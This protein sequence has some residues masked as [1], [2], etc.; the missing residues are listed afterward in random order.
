M[1][2]VIAI[3]DIGKTNKKVILFDSKLKPVYQFEQ[4]FVE[5]TDESGFSCDDIDSISKWMIETL[6]AFTKAQEF[7]IKAINFSCYGA[8]LVY[9]DAAGKVLTPVYNYLKPM[10]D[11]ISES[12][13]SKY[14]GIKEFSRRTASPALGFL[15]SGLQP[16]WLKNTYPE[17]FRKIACILHFP[18]YWSYLF[19]GKTTSEF[20]SIGC[21]TSMWDFDSMKYHQWLTDEGIHLPEPISNNQV[22]D[23]KKLNFSFKVGIGIH[24]SSASLAPYILQSKEKFILIS[25][26]TWCINMNPF[27]HEPLTS[28]QL[29][30]DCLAYMS[31]NQKPV[32]SS[33]LFMGHIHDVNLDLLVNHFKVNKNAYKNVKYDSSLIHKQNRG[34]Y[35]FFKN[36]IH[37][38]YKDTD[39]DLSVFKTFEEAYHQ[40]VVDLTELCIK[41]IN[42]I[43]PEENNI[44]NI[45]IS[46]GFSKNEIFVRYL[47]FRMSN[48]HVFTSDFD[49]S[50]AL[51]AALVIYNE[52]GVG[53]LPEINLGLKEW[54][55]N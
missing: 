5:I 8:S 16:L 14:G 29:E 41:S 28:E 37:E 53:V 39:I 6:D 21:H 19:T 54:K 55:H 3:F 42:L 27:N 9:I 38:D 48:K 22:F 35:N 10:P 33:R 32:K 49:N 40:L 15:N 45:Y 24:D 43:L 1:T 44:E 4:C 7:S 36:G 30:N 17:I 34:F 11:G 47:A 31:I 20:T 25:T 23:A 18:Q 26:G 52:F 51:G 2:D 50:S 12:V 13:Y 46:G